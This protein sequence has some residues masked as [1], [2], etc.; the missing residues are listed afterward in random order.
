MFIAAFFTVAELW[1][2][3]WADKKIQS[4]QK[5]EYHS[6][7]TKKEILPPAAM[8][9]NTG[10]H[11]SCSK[12]AIQDKYCRS[13]G[14]THWCREQEGLWGG[15]GTWAEAIRGYGDSCLWRKHKLRC[16]AIL[17]L[18]VPGFCSWAPFSHWNDHL[19]HPQIPSVSLANCEQIVHW[20]WP[21][22]VKGT[23]PLRQEKCRTHCWLLVPAVPVACTPSTE[24]NLPC[25]DSSPFLGLQLW[26][27]WSS[28]SHF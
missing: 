19:L 28:G 11:S 9:R 26:L 8:W 13:Q 6:G 12:S 24:V 4:I 2:Q 5:L 15:K 7:F 25:W 17:A 23:G 14:Q 22:Q 16:V 10:R 3:Q 1:R 27:W 21:I 20:A 18:A